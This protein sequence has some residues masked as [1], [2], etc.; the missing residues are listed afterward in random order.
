LAAAEPE[1]ISLQGAELRFWPDFLES[2][3]AANA[4]ENIRQQTPW[5]QSH[6]RIAG[7]VIPIPRLNAWYGDVGA[8]YSYSGVALETLPWTSA[9]A[10]LKSIVEAA[11]QHN[12]N[13]ALVNL[14][15]DNRDSVDWHADDEPELGLQPI[16][17]SLSLGESRTF[18]LRRKDNHREKFKLVL[19]H[20][21]LLLMA[22]NTQRQWQHRVAKEKPL[23]GERVNITFRKVHNRP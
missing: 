16:V 13:S 6:I 11:T 4:L 19:P 1:I 21:S 18:E 5:V 10:A 23:C 20:G 8:D 14:Y 12:F 7:R 22:G 15:R 9:L 2:D 3:I 17:A